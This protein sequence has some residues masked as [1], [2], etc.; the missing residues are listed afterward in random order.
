[1]NK[2]KMLL[3]VGLLSVGSL[4]IPNAA[5][6]EDWCPDNSVVSVLIDVPFAV[7]NTVGYVFDDNGRFNGILNLPFVPC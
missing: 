6:A 2:Y 7:F 1:M 5:M 4:V 3:G